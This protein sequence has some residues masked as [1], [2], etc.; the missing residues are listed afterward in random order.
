MSGHEHVHGGD[1]LLKACCC[2]AQAAAEA[3]G[4][5]TRR[6]LMAGLG[7][8]AVGAWQATTPAA[9][10]AEDATEPKV[11]PL[12]PGQKLKVQ[13][14]LTYALHQRRE[15]TS[16]RPW[17]GLLEEKDV[18][19]ETLRIQTEL[20]R[21][22]ADLPAVEFLPPIAA[23]TPAL[24]EKAAAGASDVLL[25][26]ASG[27]GGNL[28]EKLIVPDRPTLF[29]LRHNSGPVSLWYEILHPHF[30][31]KAGDACVQRGVTT[32][33][34]I[35]DKYEDLAWRLCALLALRRT[36]GQRIVAIGGAGGWGVGH[37]LAPDIAR[38]KWRLDIRDLSYEDLDK[39]IRAAKS[40][41]S[42]VA[43]ATK[44]AQ[45][46]L[47]EPGISL[48][49]DKG[50]VERAMLL[51]QVMKD[52]LKENEA[53]ALTIQ[54]CMSTVM[55]VSE[56]TACLPLSWLNDEGYLAFCESD[57]VV[58]PAGML[59]GHICQTPVFL[60]DPT[61]PHHGV[62][63]VAHCTAPR[64]MNGTDYEPTEVHTHFESDYGAA[65]KVAMRKGQIITMVAPDFASKKFVGFRGTVVDN[66][67]HA[68]CRSQTD[69]RIDGDWQRLL[70]DMQG[71]HWLMVYGDCR[72]EIGYALRRLDIEWQDVSEGSAPA[73]V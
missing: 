62:V 22:A 27:G 1:D 17:G 65:P 61:W 47:R 24:T 51:Y 50:Y 58:I 2:C 68:I 38:K 35:V 42:A 33:D 67:F 36:V 60:N 10:A 66:P 31:R 28:L 6:G 19:E 56:T 43:R 54:H 73:A 12:G 32:D 9:R 26:Y 53:T 69:V 48:K 63:T 8:A 4:W 49:T 64:R 55:Q 70:A 57:F 30:L 37:R 20:K 41:A 44:A 14:V 59:M 18:R 15:K 13:P 25:V 21:L 34:V 16:W 29:F 40:D 11:V 46:Y 3:R 5:L 72:R 39:R 71:F 7:A 52:A 23:N 45:A